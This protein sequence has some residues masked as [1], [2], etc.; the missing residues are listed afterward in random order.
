MNPRGQ[1]SLALGAALFAATA[2][3]AAPVAPLAKAS[4]DRGATHVA[5]A[6]Q[7]VQASLNLAI[8]TAC[9]GPM[10]L[11]DAPDGRPPARCTVLRLGIRHGSDAPASLPLTIPDEMS[12][13]VV[14]LVRLDAA[15]PIPQVMVSVYSGGAHC[16]EITSIV[17]R[18]ADGT[19]QA[20]PPV[21]EDDGN[22]P[23]IV[24]PGQ[25]AAPVLVTHDG[26]F[27]YTFASHAGSYL[28]LVLLGYADGALHDVTRDPANRSVLKADLDHQRSNWIAGGR[29]EPN[30]F[31]AYAVATAANL[32]DPAP[33]WRAMLAGQ[34]RSPGAVTPTPC[35]MLGQAQH[36][37]TDA[38][39][40]GVPFPQGLSLLLVHAGYLTEAQA[41][42]LSGHTAGPGAP[43]YRPDFP[44][45]PPPAD[46][47]I[48]AMLCSDGDAAKHQLQF[49]QVYYALRQQIG[50][51]GWAALKAD[52][53]RD[54][55]EADRAC[56]LPVPGAPDQT[57][58][59]QASACWIAASDRLADRYRQ[60]LSGSPLEESRRDIDT[61]L[62][63]Q[64]RLVE[65][66]YLPADTKVD[67]VY[68]EATR[69]AI[70]AWQRAAQRPT[71]DGFLSDADAAALAAPPAAA[72]APAPTPAPQTSAAPLPQPAVASPP[73]GTNPVILGLGGLVI[74]LIAVIVVLLVRRR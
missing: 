33:A 37:C 14:S 20:T 38:Q 62:A 9:A 11:D 30:G 34:D 60:R 44:C 58:P 36:T 65:L 7:G 25:G 6:A 67:G 27:N 69:A 13:P 64:Q 50:P 10:I 43:R 16:C 74:V 40:K 52:V 18:R 31:L 46:N 4:L 1:F 26:R 19:W 48:A 39:K 45:D 66:G 12:F 68:G 29:S 42:D 59:A 57:M 56:G 73:R 15:S 63:L 51:E 35:E 47:A 71:A 54:E 17:G 8:S 22:Q 72:P 32:G 70:A 3:H 61:H 2:A 55:N 23:E 24:A 5:I 28:P 49:D 21:T 53:I 41:R